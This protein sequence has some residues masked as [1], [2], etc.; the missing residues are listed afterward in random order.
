MKKLSLYVGNSFPT[1]NFVRE[2]YHYYAKSPR[3]S[4]IVTLGAATHVS[5]WRNI[6][7]L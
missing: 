3:T 4:L 2:V 7:E 6:T 5:W 1:T